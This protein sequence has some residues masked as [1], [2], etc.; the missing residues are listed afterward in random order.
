[1][2]SYWLGARQGIRASVLKEKRRQVTTNDGIPLSI[3]NATFAP[4]S[5]G[6]MVIETGV[7]IQPGN[8][9]GLGASAPLRDRETEGL[10]HSS[11]S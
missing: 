4:Q 8:V 5:Q 6:D 3:Q 9:S 7:D 10:Y 1:M 11:G 2:A